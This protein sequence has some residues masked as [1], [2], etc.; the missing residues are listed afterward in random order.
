LLADV[1]DSARLW[2]ADSDE[3]T[4][5]LVVLDRVVAQAVAAHGGVRSVECCGDTCF[6]AAFED[7]GDAVACA[8]EVQQAH[9]GLIRL[10]VGVHTC[11]VPLRYKGGFTG[12]EINC[13]AR[14][15]DLA[16]GGQIL[17]S[18]STEELIAEQT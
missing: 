18:G 4:A 17:L 6:V 11:Q 15:S 5:A 10:R 8:L 1:E 14:L 2:T 7:A 16:Q 9:L 3:M 12:S 13:T